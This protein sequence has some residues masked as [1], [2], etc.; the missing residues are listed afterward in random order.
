MV[1]AT[2][3]ALE[4]KHCQQHTATIGRSSGLNLTKITIV[5][6]SDLRRKLK[7]FKLS[8]LG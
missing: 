8:F 5:Q 2:S 3:L 6:H 4:E 1:V 7:A